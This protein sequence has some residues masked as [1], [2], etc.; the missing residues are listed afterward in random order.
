MRFC[1]KSGNYTVQ[2]WRLTQAAMSIVQNMETM[3][4]CLKS[5]N[6][7]VRNY[8][9]LKNKVNASMHTIINMETMC[10]YHKSGN[11]IGNT[12]KQA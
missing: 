5:G 7:T 11:Y 12:E 6:Y 1:R 10:C 9:I 2:N 3:C 8:E 4:F